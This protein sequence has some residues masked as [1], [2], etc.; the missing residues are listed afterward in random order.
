VQRALAKFGALGRGYIAFARAQPGLFRT[1]FAPDAPAMP[2]EH[3]PDG[4][5]QLLAATLDELVEVGYLPRERRELAELA[6]WS[7]VHGLA[8]LLDGPLRDL[9]KDVRDAA[10][11]NTM[12]T[13]GHGLR[14]TGLTHAQEA[15]MAEELSGRA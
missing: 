4:P 2:A 8:T 7:V 15:Q 14:G 11:V 10:I 12:L 5:Y 1:V 13:L 9:P 6:A 3:S